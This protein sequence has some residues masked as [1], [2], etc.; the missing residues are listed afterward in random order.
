MYRGSRQPPGRLKT[1]RPCR[2][3]DGKRIVVTYV[4]GAASGKLVA[5][6]AFRYWSPADWVLDAWDWWRVRRH[7]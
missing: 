2:T 5:S 3:L 7:F 6:R 1:T 4:A